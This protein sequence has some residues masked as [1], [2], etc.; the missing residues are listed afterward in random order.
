MKKLFIVL[1]SLFFIACDSSEKEKT[2]QVNGACFDTLD[3]QCGSQNNPDS[4]EDDGDS[5]EEP[6]GD[7]DDE[8][9]SEDPEPEPTV[10]EG[11]L[12]P[13]NCEPAQLGLL[14]EYSNSE[15]GE[16][17]RTAITGQVFLEAPAQLDNGQ[18]DYSDIQMLPAYGASILAIAC[19]GSFLDGDVVN[20]VG[21]YFI[22]VPVNI[23]VSLRLVASS[24]RIEVTEFLGSTW[25]LDVV[26]NLN[27]DQTY[28]YDVT[29]S[30]F[31]VDAA[32][33]ENDVVAGT[34]VATGDVNITIPLGWNGA[35]Y[36]AASRLSAP[37]AILRTAFI[38]MDSLLAIV[39]DGSQVN[40]LGKRGEG[41]DFGDLKLAWSSE[42]TTV[43]GDVE[44]GLLG[45]SFYE[46]SNKF[47]YL[48]GEEGVNTDEF[49]VD[50]INS[51]VG[52]FVY[53]S[54]SRVDRVYGDVEFDAKHDARV[55]FYEGF[56]VGL[57]AA[58]TDT[59]LFRDSK[60]VQATTPD[61]TS[62]D[63]ESYTVTSPGWYNPASVA[64]IINDILDGHS[65]KV[66]DDGLQVLSFELFDAVGEAANSGAFVTIFSFIDG[67]KRSI[68]DDVDGK[69]ED[70]F[71]DDSLP[72]TGTSQLN[73]LLTAQ[74]IEVVSALDDHLDSTEEVDDFKEVNG[75]P[76][77]FNI[78]TWGGPVGFFSEDTSL[79][80]SAYGTKEVNDGGA[81]NSLS[82]LP[83]ID[84]A[85]IMGSFITTGFLPGSASTVQGPNQNLIGSV[86]R[87]FSR[88][89]CSTNE[90][91]VGNYL[92]NYRHI[93]FT[94]FDKSRYEFT[95]ERI[96]SKPD[97]T[98]N[99]TWLSGL[100]DTVVPTARILRFSD[101]GAL[102]EVRFVTGA[103]DKNINIYES[104]EPGQYILE[105]STAGNAGVEGQAAG[106]VCYNI[107]IN[108]HEWDVVD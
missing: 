82:T 14:S 12:N 49:D 24:F 17:S 92:G 67:L 102:S 87:E 59:G 104:L 107:E 58:L 9:S 19:D 50:V 11:I 23:D 30:L 43:V 33:Y 84:H 38:T 72:F 77:E 95:S 94:V 68:Y 89:V 78:M 54:V 20:G 103:I 1:L 48:L 46:D 7:T 51:L 99:I 60:G 36:D 37:F 86:I 80:S 105:F 32:K 57:A 91:G 97:L 96:D 79:L 45:K 41:L 63:I 10:V 5:G 85:G 34:T 90:F 66:D 2:N 15:P 100:E 98:F 70:P 16:I 25:A 106:E 65:G 83:Y 4:E 21:D 18:L 76:D 101:T 42:N 26:D 31:N 6:G 44:E 47:I 56:K 22:R 55:A 53:D 64:S 71:V 75:D 40:G 3:S 29:Q 39:T 73:S 8:V 74:S 62:I 52:L 13:D 93:A 88:D 35:S 108:D 81:A 27:N 28:V 69:E 61:S